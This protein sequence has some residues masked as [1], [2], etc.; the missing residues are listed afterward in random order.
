MQFKPCRIFAM[1]LPS[2]R[3]GA[4]LM[5]PRFAV[6]Y[7]LV[8]KTLSPVPWIN[9]PHPARG[10]GDPSWDEERAPVW[11]SDGGVLYPGAPAIAGNRC[12]CMTRLYPP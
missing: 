2:E 9:S 11:F 1:K 12:N 7:D 4:P 10:I 3:H 6:M 8:A 5:S